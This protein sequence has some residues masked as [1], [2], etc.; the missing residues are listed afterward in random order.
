MQTFQVQTSQQAVVR[1][2]PGVAVLAGQD[3]HGLLV[4]L[5]GLRPDPQQLPVDLTLRHPRPVAVV[6]LQLEE[7]QPGD[8]KKTWFNSET[9]LKMGFATQLKIKIKSSI[10]VS[11][12]GLFFQSSFGFTFRLL[13]FPRRELGGINLSQCPEKRPDCPRFLQLETSKI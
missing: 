13:T 4:G 7:L 12:T 2:A 3:A 10:W 9:S 11:N 8:D 6:H 5:P 1:L